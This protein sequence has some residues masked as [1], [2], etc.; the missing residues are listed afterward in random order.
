[1]LTNK[2]ASIILGM[3][4]R[5][6]NKHDIAAWFGV[7][8]A[9]IKEVED[10]SHGSIGAAPAADL[11][12]KG[13]PGPKGRRLRTSVRNALEILQNKG[14]EGVS[15]AIAVLDEASKRYDRHEA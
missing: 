15:E 4:A 3:V 8:Q 1:M 13:A 5:G 10:G 14:P 7:N 6:D 12:P 2:D 11:L 9:R